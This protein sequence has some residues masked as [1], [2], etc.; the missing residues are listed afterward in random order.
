[1]TAANVPARN[2]LADFETF[3]STFHDQCAANIDDPSFLF[4]NYGLAEADNDNYD[5]VLPGD[6]SYRYHLNLLR[7]ML[8]GVDLRRKTVLDLSSGRGGNCHYLLRYSNARLVYGLDRCEPYVR[9]CRRTLPD[10]GLRTICADALRLPMRDKSFDV[11]L[12]VQSSHCYGDFAAFLREAHRVLRPGGTLA[13]ADAWDL[14]MFPLDWNARRTQLSESGLQ[15]VNQEEV[16]ASVSVAIEQDD[17]FGPRF[18]R[19]VSNLNSDLF[20]SATASL[21]NIQCSLAEHRAT[22][23]MYRLV[24]PFSQDVLQ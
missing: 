8:H 4:F 17:G 10:A 20:L 3:L 16:G 13:Y 9:F 15:I 7:R 12:N 23:W 11:V 5:W 14:D 18:R 2:A 19:A 6:R 22:Y 1:M 24:K 21:R